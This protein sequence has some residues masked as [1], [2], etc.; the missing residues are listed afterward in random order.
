M[1]AMAVFMPT[2]SATAPNRAP[3][4]RQAQQQAVEAILKLGGD[5][6]FDYQRPDPNKPNVFDQQAKPMDPK[7]FHRVILVSLRESKVTDDDLKILAKLPYLENLDLTNT[8]VSSAGLAHLKG[9]K[10]LRVL[11]LWRT[12]VDDKGLEHIKGLTKMWQLVLD[13][14]KVTDAGLVHLKGMTD[15]EEWLGLV[16]TQVTDEGL[17]HLEGLTKLRSLNLRHTRVTEAG[18]KKL[19]EALP[20]TRISTRS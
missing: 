20:N 13:E 1:L 18:V 12:K 2:L 7:G 15:L 4:E 17:K 19:Q 3:I 10:N 16:G 9:L 5:V 6:R 14:T 11:S 8:R